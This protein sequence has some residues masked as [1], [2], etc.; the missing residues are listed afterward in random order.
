ME[1]AGSSGLLTMGQ[2]AK[3]LLPVEERNG[4]R[5][6]LLERREFGASALFCCPLLEFCRHK[7]TGFNRHRVEVLACHHPA[8]SPD[9]LWNFARSMLFTYGNELSS[10]E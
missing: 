8:S 10:G 3:L 2:E 9:E 5:I 4:V 1:N 7:W 6:L